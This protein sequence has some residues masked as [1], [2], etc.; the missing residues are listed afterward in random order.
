MKK[1]F[2]Q[3]KI[4]LMDLIEIIKRFKKRL[5]KFLGLD[6]LLK[7]K[8][9]SFIIKYLKI[10]IKIGILFKLSLIIISFF[11]NNL[12]LN[13]MGV[14]TSLYL[15]LKDDLFNKIKD[16]ILDKLDVNPLNKTKDEFV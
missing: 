14:L 11:D 5:L 8:I 4:S 1:R 3:L 9:V 12:Y 15:L 16:D 6:K 13:L 7:L 2:I 10:G